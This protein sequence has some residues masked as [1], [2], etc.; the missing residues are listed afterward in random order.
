MKYDKTLLIT[1]IILILIGVSAP[2]GCYILY[3]NLLTA[4]NCS[5]DGL[6]TACMFTAM[7]LMCGGLAGGVAA[8]SES[9]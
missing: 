9:K 1:G 6:G 3:C 5:S 8:I 4:Y 2:I 7:I